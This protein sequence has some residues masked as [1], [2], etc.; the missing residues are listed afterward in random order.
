MLLGVDSAEPVLDT[1]AVCVGVIVTEGV[2]VF[3]P[4]LV[5]VFVCVWVRVAVMVTLGLV[6]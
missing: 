1:D 2:C 3:A 6:V 5:V 4:V